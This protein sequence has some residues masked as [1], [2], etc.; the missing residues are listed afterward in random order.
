MEG[1]EVVGEVGGDHFFFF[2]FFFF[3]V[4]FVYGVLQAILCVEEAFP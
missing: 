1:V 3:V 4:V 2:F